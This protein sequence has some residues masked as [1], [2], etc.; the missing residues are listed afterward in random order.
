MPGAS[1]RH[2]AKGGR[3]GTAAALR[4]LVAN[5]LS[6]LWTIFLGKTTHSVNNPRKAPAATNAIILRHLLIRNPKIY[7]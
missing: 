2:G 4:P 5:Y 1:D 7:G 3:E 6:L